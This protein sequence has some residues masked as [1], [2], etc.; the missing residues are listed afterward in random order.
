V[1]KNVEKRKEKSDHLALANALGLVQQYKTS[2]SIP[3]KVS[4]KEI[5]QRKSEIAIIKK[6]QLARPFSFF[7]FHHNPRPTL[8]LF[9][10]SSNPILP[11]NP[12]H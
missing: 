7:F 6:Y 4:D 11:N 2:A 10:L 3:K 12:S 1:I 8:S 5:R 9:K